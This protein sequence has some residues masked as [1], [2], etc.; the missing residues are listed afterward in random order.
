M[1]NILIFLFISTGI[2]I[3]SAIAISLAPMINDIS[4]MSYYSPKDLDCEIFS[5]QEEIS[6]YNLDIFQ[7]LKTFKNLCKRQ[8]AAYNLEYSS[9]IID[10]VLSFLCANLALLSFFKEGEGHQNKIGIFGIIT[11][12]IGFILTLIYVCFN[13]YV[14]TNDVAFGII[15]INDLAGNGPE[16][17]G[18]ITKLFSNGAKYKYNGKKYITSYEANTGFNSQFLRYSELGDKQYNYDKDNYIKYMENKPA[19]SNSINECNIGNSYLLTNS[20]IKINNCEYLFSEPYNNC[21]NKYLY[22]RWVA[23]LILSVFIVVLHLALAVFGILGFIDKETP[24]EFGN[25][26]VIYGNK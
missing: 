7:K 5:N 21:S 3:L 24:K 26:L 17:N 9:L 4:N 16:L 1:N 20:N 13:G 14:F 8:K 18:G 6:K 12:I 19:N 15:N 23:T 25:D 11:G 2:L 22:D 10:A